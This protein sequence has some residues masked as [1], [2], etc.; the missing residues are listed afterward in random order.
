[1]SDDEG[2]QWIFGEEDD[3]EYAYV[4]YAGG[5]KGKRSREEGAVAR[6]DADATRPRTSMT[7][8]EDQEG[9]AR[10]EGQLQQSERAAPRIPDAF[11]GHHCPI[12]LDATQDSAMIE[13]CH[14]LYCKR[15][16]FEVRVPF[17]RFELV[18]GYERR[19]Q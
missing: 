10:A 18:I 4:D 3:S 5:G 9:E 1:M 13:S 12:C 17:P 7:C 16:L 2:R 8:A 11:C 14:H 15:C 19:Q 6:S